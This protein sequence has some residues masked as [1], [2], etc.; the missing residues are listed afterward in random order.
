MPKHNKRIKLYKTSRQVDAYKTT[1]IA[2]L[3]YFKAPLP[4]NPYGMTI[5]QIERLCRYYGIDYRKLQTDA[6]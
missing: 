2:L 5:K 6:V 1:L 3:K 4:E